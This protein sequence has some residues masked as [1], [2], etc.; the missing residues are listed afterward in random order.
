LQKWNKWVHRTTLPTNML[1][2][3]TIRQRAS[4]RSNESDHAARGVWAPP[5]K[6]S[7]A[8]L[9]QARRVFFHL[10]KD[11]TGGIDIAELRTML[12]SMGHDPADAEL[13]DLIASVDQDH[14]RPIQMREFLQ[15]YTQGVDAKPSVG[16]LDVNDAFASF[17]GNPRD[18]ESNVGADTVHDHML[19]RY[20]L[21][22]NCSELFGTAEG[23]ELTK[24]HFQMLLQT[25]KPS[26]RQHA[27]R[28]AVTLPPIR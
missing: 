11:G 26:S 15:L 28:G 4:R 13:H 8:E 6:P 2:H 19:D 23:G 10:D 22:I 25:P 20:G 27:R 17:G 21:D 7:T 5:R 24:K 9:G 12:R 16:S 14:H 1:T 3:T 18:K